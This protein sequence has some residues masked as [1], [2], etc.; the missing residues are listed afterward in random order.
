MQLVVKVLEDKSTLFQ[1]EKVAP[2]SRRAPVV[3]LVSM[4]AVQPSRDII[5]A[6]KNLHRITSQPGVELIRQIFP[7]KL[8]KPK[9]KNKN[10]IEVSYTGLMILVRVSLKFYLKHEKILPVVLR[11]ARKEFVKRRSMVYTLLEASGCKVTL[12]TGK[13]LIGSHLQGEKVAEGVS[14]FKGVKGFLSKIIEPFLRLDRVPSRHIQDYAVPDLPV[15]HRVGSLITNSNKL[16]GF[17]T[18]TTGPLLICGSSNTEVISALQQ[19][20]NSLREASP[21]KRIFVIDTKNELNGL[22]NHLQANPAKGLYPQVFRL[23]TNIHLNLCD[24]I[25]PLSQSGE[26]QEI[27]A[28]AAWK[29]HLIS[30]I[31]LSSLNTSEYLTARYAVPLE[32]QIRKTAE[33]LHLFTLRDVILSLGGATET[34]TTEA[35]DNN[36]MIFSDMM[37]IEAIVGVLE[38]F[39]SFPEVNYSS[40]TG[41]YSNTMVRDGTITFFQFGTQPQLI[42]RATVNFLLQYLSQIM[43]DGCV[44]LT[45]IDEYLDQHPPRDRNTG[46][47][48]LIQAC[49]SLAAKN[50]VVLGNHRLQSLVGNM[51]TFDEIRNSL[52]LKLNNKYDRE[53]VFNQHELDFGQQQKPYENQHSLGIM[54]GEGLLFR[55]DAPKNIGFHLKL[56]SQIPVD[57]TPIRVP[58]T[59]RRGLETLG[60]TPAKYEILMKLLKLLFNQPC[61]NDEVMALVSTTKQGELSLDYFKSLELYETEITGGSTYWLITKK[62]REY[63]TKQHDFI[64]SL[65][66]PLNGAEV[67]LARQELERLESFYDVSADKEVRKE[68]NTKVKNLVGRL[69]NYTRQLRA[70]S[71][72]WSR[73]AEYHDLAMINSLEWQDF[74]HLFDLAH[75]MVNDLLLDIKQLQEKRSNEEIQRTLQ[76]TSITSSSSKRDLD[77]FLPDNTFIRLQQI[78]QELELDP[79]P[80]SGILDIYFALHAKGRSLFEELANNK[81]K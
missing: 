77:D 6:S 41:H 18:L 70:T 20:L 37:A 10:Q 60:L 67:S 1:I 81:E 75:G 64:N 63:Y 36:T 68:T 78:S 4:F 80:K 2:D 26:K 53:I 31:L 57:Q 73:I 79:Y 59:K 71:N 5:D 3:Q 54:E 32:S 34:N 55:E 33:N 66:A 12:V 38:Q 11:E 30:Q 76:N 9:N 43:K 49:N 45:H 50:L 52:Y 44:V 29:S 58:R 74:R 62:G 28:Q 13:K 48:N 69:V 27:E 22:I 7:A 14:V 61:P 65:P 46:T 21:A 25:V 72:P 56:E 35:S 39:R 40:F 51:N 47:S 15:V 8:A 19:L 24:V 23:G 42:R 16:V 17:P